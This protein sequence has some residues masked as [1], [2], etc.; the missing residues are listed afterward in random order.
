MKFE[1][2]TLEEYTDKALLAELRR[3]AELVNTPKLSISQ[4]SA[5]AKVHGSTLQKRFG[6]WRKALEKA[7]LSERIDSNNIGTSNDVVLK[8][9]SKAAHELNKTVLTLDEFEAHTGISG[10]PVRRHFGSWEKALKAAGLNQSLLGR[11]YTDEECFE[12]IL[13]LW[14]HYGRQP[15]F[16]ELKRPPSS[17]GPKAYIRRWRGWRAALSAF[18]KRV[19]ESQEA[20]APQPVATEPA[21][22]ESAP[23]SV[24]PRSISLSLRYRVLARD[25]FRCVACG[26]SPAK[27]GTVELHVD[28]IQPWSRGG[29]N[30]EE[31]LRTLCFKCNLGKGVRLEDAQ[32]GVPADRPSPAGSAGG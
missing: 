29:K 2:S 32:Q 31:N 3:V 21:A 8:A 17:V 5:I 25:S 26:A 12:N 18:V 10:A 9:I 28:H 20:V 6:G 30:T 23:S 11:R 4:F 13:A 16:G 1:L 19:N 15:I 24:V 22:A 7:G 27:D 14:T